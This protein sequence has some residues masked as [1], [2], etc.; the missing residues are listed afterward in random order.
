MVVV[1]LYI[2]LAVYQL[3]VFDIYFTNKSNKFCYH[4]ELQE[5]GQYNLLRSLKHS[6]M[7]VENL[8]AGYLSGKVWISSKLNLQTAQWDL[9]VGREPGLVSVSAG[10]EVFLGQI[11]LILP[12]I[13]VAK[14]GCVAGLYLDLLS[15]FSAGEDP[16]A[17]ERAEDGIEVA[18]F[19]LVPAFQAFN[20]LPMGMGV[21]QVHVERGRI[22][23]ADPIEPSFTAP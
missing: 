20:H 14:L 10:E 19:D 17:L 9:K 4:D 3:S 18:L 2:K 23:G 5:V 15:H 11:P 1:L 22:G 8:D 21:S 13:H 6:L 7:A 12:Y 16:V